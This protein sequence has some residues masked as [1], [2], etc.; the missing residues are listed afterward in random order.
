MGQKVHPIGFR[1]GIYGDWQAHWFARRGY[2]KE[3]AEDLQIR[4]YLKKKL[5]R[6][7]V[8]KVIIDKAG[9]NVRV[10][11]H[12]GR[13]GVVIG[14]KGSGIESLKSDLYKTFK[15]NIE[16][17]VKE[18][19]LPQISARLIGDSIAEQLERRVGFKR[20]MKKAGFAAM[21]GGAKGVKIYCGGRLGGAEIA[22]TEALRL[23]S[24][25]LHTLRS[26][27][28]YAI[29]EAKTTYGI[30]GIKVWVYHGLYQDTK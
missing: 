16:V 19:R 20:A 4:S 7:E 13:P 25:P 12:S 28:D 9:E 10:T 21:K 2:G 26:N 24:V 8:E 15:K 14:K 23:G 18:V 30:I 5:A 11:I 27:I 22:R 1:L 3:L 6:S 17:S 29:V